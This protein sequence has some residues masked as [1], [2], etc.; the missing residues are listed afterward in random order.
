MFCSVPFSIV[1]QL[2]FAFT[3]EGTQYSYTKLPWDTLTAFNHIIFVGNIS[4]RSPCLCVGKMTCFGVCFGGNFFMCSCR[5]TV[6]M[7]VGEFKILLCGYLEPELIILNPCSV[8]SRALVKF[9]LVLGMIL[10]NLECFDSFC[11][12]FLYQKIK[13]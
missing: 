10:W 8:N 6:F 3:S 2:Q 11:L 1:S 5:F 7:G 4:C 9:P 13:S 12:H